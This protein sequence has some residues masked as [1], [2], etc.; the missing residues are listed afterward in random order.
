MTDSVTRSPIELS[1]SCVKIFENIW[2]YDKKESLN[3]L[4]K[5]TWERGWKRQDW[6]VGKQ[7]GSEEVDWKEKRPRRTKKRQEEE[8]EKKRLSR[9]KKRLEQEEKKNWRR[10]KD[11]RRRNKKEWKKRSKQREASPKK[12]VL[13]YVADQRAMSTSRHEVIPWLHYNNVFCNSITTI[14]KLQASV[15]KR[16]YYSLIYKIL[17]NFISEHLEREVSYVF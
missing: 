2:K 8:E 12:W 5:K 14:N 13:V 1:D 15:W 17:F 16:L 6:S 3:Q 7:V 4:V 11:W 10:N 9:T